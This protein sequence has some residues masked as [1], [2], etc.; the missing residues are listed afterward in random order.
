MKRRLAALA[1]CLVVLAAP[2]RA[3]DR[4]VHVYNWSDYVDARTLDDF[5]RETGIRVVYDT[6]DSNEMLEAKLLAGKTGYDVVAP[7]ATFLQRQIQAGVYQPLD[8]AKL[9]NAKGLWPE[10]MKRL[11]AYDPGNRYAVN[12]MWFT[13]GVAYNKEKV[14]QR[15]GAR[16]LDSWDVVLKPE[17]LKKVADCGVYMLDSPEDLFSIA[18]RTLGLPPDSKK[19]DDIRRAGNLL[20]QLRPYVRK[21]H[22]SE[23]INALANGDACLAIGWAGDAFQARNRAEEAK[24]GVEIDYVIPREGTLM[25]LD[26]FA[27]PKDAPH[28]A[29]AHA[30]IDFML[31]P[32][33]AARNSSV[34]NFANGVLAAKALVAPEVAQNRAIYPDETVMARLFTVTPYDQAT[35]RIVTREWTRVKTGR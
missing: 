27:I 13:T 15:L 6:Y 24:N 18:L 33:V 19:Q 7:S 11:E 3:Q 4:V 17:N 25:S 14:A 26:S 32:E 23:Y 1:A 9:P 22:S 28:V 20:A 16:A 10:V 8:K 21:F 34:T 2:A 31:R 29:E 5:T 35:Q 12:Y 30:F